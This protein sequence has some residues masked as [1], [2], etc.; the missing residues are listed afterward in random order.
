MNRSYGYLVKA[1][2]ELA[3]LT[4]QCGLKYVHRPIPA[5]VSIRMDGSRSNASKAIRRPRAGGR[6]AR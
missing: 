2:N 5:K 1:L 3:S 4:A 6:N